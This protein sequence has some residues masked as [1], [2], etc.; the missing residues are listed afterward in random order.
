MIDCEGNI[1]IRIAVCDDD[2]K[3]VDSI[4]QYLKKKTEQMSDETVKVSLYESGTSFLQDIENGAYFHIVFMDIELNGKNGIDIGHDLR[5]RTN[6]DDIIMIYISVHNSYF[7]PLSAVGSFRFLRKPID[8]KELDEVFS[9]ALAFALKLKDVTD[10]DKQF[11]FN[12]G[13]VKHS[14]KTE[15]IAYMKTKRDVLEIYVWN[16]QDKSITFF[17]KM[18]SSLVQALEQLPSNQFVRCGNSHIVNLDY[19]GKVSYKTLTFA[20]NAMTTLPI[21]RIYID[22]TRNA[23]YRRRGMQP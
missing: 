19:V 15:E 8:N 23:F 10:K 22:K 5:K 13:W 20:D 18:Y 1:M 14:V 9:R 2:K 11:H 7:E 21:G 12:I 16:K 3:I 17:E 4:Q 6:G